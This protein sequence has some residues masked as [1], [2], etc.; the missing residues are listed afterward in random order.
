MTW[1]AGAGLAAFFNAIGFIA[2]IGNIVLSALIY[3]YS[4]KK[5]RVKEFEE[6]VKSQHGEVSLNSLRR[7]LNLDVVGK[8]ATASDIA[9]LAM[10]EDFGVGKRI[11]T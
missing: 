1:A 9:W 6:L 4:R 11:T 10:H 5:K 3:H 2:L 7:D 8:M